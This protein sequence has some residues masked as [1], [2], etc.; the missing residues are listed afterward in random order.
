MDPNTLDPKLKATYDRV[1]G[2]QTT[3]P[4]QPAPAADPVV[5]GVNPVISTTAPLTSDALQQPASPTPAAAYTAD[6]LS[7]Q[8][9]IQAPVVAGAQV[10]VAGQAVP[11]QPSAI[12]KFLYIVGAVVFFLAYTFI[13]I[14]IFNLPL[15]F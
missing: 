11:H 10:A 13:W 7:F 9:A 5:N 4:N 14:K 2:T 8:A 3:A 12:L 6:N 15:P 1:M